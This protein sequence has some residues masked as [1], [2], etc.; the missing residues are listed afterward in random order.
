MRKGKR[1]VERR[2]LKDLP[3]VGEETDGKGMKDWTP[4][5]NRNRL[6]TKTQKRNLKRRKGGAGQSQGTEKKRAYSV[7]KFPNRTRRNRGERGEIIA[8]SV[9][10][11]GKGG[12]TVKPGRG[13]EQEGIGERIIQ[14]RGRGEKETGMFAK[15]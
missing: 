12:Y 2:R 1:E 5:H 7:K 11:T 14:C 3:Y 13:E 9:R 8:L 15:S 10:R 6:L 4:R